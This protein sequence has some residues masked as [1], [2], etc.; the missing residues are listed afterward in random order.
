[1]ANIKRLVI[2]CSD[3]MWGDVEVIRQWHKQRGWKDIGY[4][5]VILN[6]YRGSHSPFDPK[7]DGLVELGRGLNF[8]PILEG[9]EI[10]AHAMGFN[11]ESIGVCLIGTGTYT[12]SQVQ[13][14]EAF[15]VL[16]IKVVPGIQIVGHYELDR[17][18]TCPNMDMNDWR[19]RLHSWKGLEFTGP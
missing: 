13:A 3:S 10:G 8:D 9:N 12:V 18:K 6:G 1:M 15:C 4:N 7:V 11:S 5:A 19:T 14:L 16:W 2:H 17:R